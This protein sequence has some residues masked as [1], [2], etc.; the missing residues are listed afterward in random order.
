MSARGLLIAVGI[1]ALLGV[2]WMLDKLGTRYFNADSYNI[3][4]WVIPIIFIYFPHIKLQ[5]I[6][7]EF[8][9]ASWKVVVL[10]GLNVVGYLLQLKALQIAEATRV[11][12]IIQTYTLL[13]VIAGIVLLHERENMFRKLLAGAMALIGVFLLV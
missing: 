13:T 5:A 1:N 2:A 11:I 8:Q 9:Q 10:A 3:F 7:K 4:V 6:K 12:P